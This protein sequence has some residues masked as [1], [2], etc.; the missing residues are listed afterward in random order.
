MTLTSPFYAYVVDKAQQISLGRK[1]FLPEPVLVFG[2]YVNNNGIMFTYESQGK[3]NTLE[4]QH[5]LY[6]RPY[7]EKQTR[8]LIKLGT[9]NEYV[10]MTIE[11][12]VKQGLMEAPEVIIEEEEE[13]EEADESE[14]S[15]N[16]GQKP[17]RTVPKRGK[18]K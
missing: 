11:D 16:K 1:V 12:A 2:S 17:K 6:D 15:P 4:G 5:I 14:P 3:I 9:G 7:G 10:C 18:R 13:D 8:K